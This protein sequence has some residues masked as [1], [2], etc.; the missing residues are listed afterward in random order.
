MRVSP[1]PAVLPS[2]GMITRNAGCTT[3]VASVIH[4]PVSLSLRS[5]ED[6]TRVQVRDVF[7]EFLLLSRIIFEV[8]I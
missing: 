1:T 5:L 4:S 8:L 2:I 3:N 6:A 7:A